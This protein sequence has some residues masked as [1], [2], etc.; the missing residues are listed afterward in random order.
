MLSILRRIFLFDS[1]SRVSSLDGVAAF[2]ARPRE[3][4]DTKPCVR[5]GGMI[6]GAN[7]ET[8]RCVARSG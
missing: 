3:F 4:R 6:N 7:I 1:I 5:Q 8:L 2:R